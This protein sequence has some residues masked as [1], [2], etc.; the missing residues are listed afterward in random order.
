MDGL[1]AL[2]GR[3]SAED[4]LAKRRDAL[5]HLFVQFACGGVEDMTHPAGSDDGK[6][7]AVGDIVVP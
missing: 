7:L 2:L 3:G 5:H 1:Y 6:S 4:V